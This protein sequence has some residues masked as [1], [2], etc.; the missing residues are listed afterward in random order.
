MDEMAQHAGA[1]SGWIK[2]RD[3]FDLYS[4]EAGLPEQIRDKLRERIIEGLKN[5]PAHGGGISFGQFG[6]EVYESESEYYVD[7]AVFTYVMEQLRG[8]GMHSD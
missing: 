5:V 2:V 1:N 8:G 7:A 6:L 3:A 4:K